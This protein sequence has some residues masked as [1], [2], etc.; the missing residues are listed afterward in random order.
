MEVKPGYKRSEVGFIPADWEIHTIGNSMRLINGRAFKLEDWKELGLPIIRIQ[1]L[2]DAETPFNHYSGPVED[3][4]RIEAGDI[5]FAWSGTK[6]TSFGARVWNGPAGVLNQHIFKVIPD[7]TKLTPSY[8]FLAL[9]KAQENIEKQ[10]HGFKAS[11]VHVKKS[12]L[13]GIQLPFPPS[14]AEQKAIA[15]V[16]CDVDTL[17]ESLE[18]LIAK[19][20]RI[21]R[22]AVQELLTGKK[23]LPGFSGEWEVRAFSEVCWFQEGPGVRNSQFTANGVKLLNGTNIFRGVLNLDTTSRFISEKEAN[24]AYAHFLADDGDIVI[25]SS[26]ITI[27]R[28]HDKVAFVRECDLPFCMNTST[29]RFQPFPEALASGFLYQFLRSDVFKRMIGG[30]ATG[31]AQLNFG[32]SHVAKVTISLPSLPEQTAIIDVLSDID[33]EI[34]A[35]ETKLAKARHLKEGVMQELLTGR[36]RLV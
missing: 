22:G 8:A 3:R 2:N 16:L 19:K 27:E 15:T 33:T 13:V 31:S 7:E 9:R 1:N 29:I 4:H 36:V 20:Q 34:V 14:K 12:D 21:K 35:L 17:I 28:F 26:G 32:P 6:G 24:G 5:L 25:A 30:Q 23:R 18:I 11:F 10:A